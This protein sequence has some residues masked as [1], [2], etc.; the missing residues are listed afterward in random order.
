MPAYRY[1]L[2]FLI[3][4]LL[5]NCRPATAQ[6]ALHTENVF[7]ITF[8]GLRWQELFTGADP[9]LIGHEDYVDDADGLRSAYFTND[10][11][12][13]RRRL[14]PFFWSTLAEKGQLY[15]NHD[16]GCRVAVTNNQWFSYPGYNEILTGKA[17]PDIDSNAKI[18]NKNQTV[19]EFLNARP[20]FEGHVAAFGSWDV[21]PYIINEERSGVPVNAGFKPA[22]GPALSEREQFLNTLQ[23]E[24]PSPWGTV[25]HDAFTHHFAL[26]Y[27]K[28]NHPRVVYFAYGETDD[29]AH[30]GDFEA[31][32]KS[33]HQTDAFIAALWDYVNR[34]PFYRGNTTFVITTDHGRG[35]QPLDTWRS[36]GTDIEGADE[37][38][39][40]FLGPDTPALGE[41][42]SCDLGQNQVA[43]S[44]AA[45]LGLDFGSHQD[46]GPPVN[47]AFRE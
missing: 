18:P 12:E 28:K 9:Q 26:E 14:M 25:R 15:G 22:T 33:A 35:T 30:D 2:S 10:P 42:E 5:L 41:V 39:M 44:V 13:R 6:D 17:D 43:A 36:H 29:F 40:A 1:V 8:D 24:I 23:Q 38:W 7:L 4:F 19:L 32:L 20:G 27:I 16:L 47:S 45:F 34:D 3:P 11:I 37:I 21:F 31:Y 46:A